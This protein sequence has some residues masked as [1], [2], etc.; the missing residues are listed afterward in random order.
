MFSLPSRIAPAL[1]S[2]STI[3]ASIVGTKSFRILDPHVVRMPRVRNRSLIAYGTPCRGPRYRPFRISDSARFA[4]AAAA[5]A[6]IVMNE[7]IL[8]SCSS[9][10]SRH[11]LVTSTG[12]T[13]LVRSAF[14]SA[15]R[16]QSVMTAVLTRR[17]LALQRGRRRCWVRRRGDRVS[18]V[19]RPVRAASRHQ[20]RANEA[21]VTPPSSFV[22]CACRAARS[23]FDAA[24]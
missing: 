4:A 19:D 22:T 12:E 7:L 2:R 6:R 5:F 10:R 15:A 17:S 18:R 23:A 8:P 21:P 11:A 9:M 20:L 1:A 14:D 24:F 16:V 13:S 3:A